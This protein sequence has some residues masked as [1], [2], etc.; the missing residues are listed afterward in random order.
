[1]YH[2][3]RPPYSALLS[4]SGG[5]DEASRGKLGRL[6]WQAAWLV[7]GWWFGGLMPKNMEVRAHQGSPDATRRGPTAEHP[8]SRWSKA[9]AVFVNVLLLL[10]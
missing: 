7:A 8:C 6:V 4:K 9:P 1:M 3:P 2:G 5:D 10:L